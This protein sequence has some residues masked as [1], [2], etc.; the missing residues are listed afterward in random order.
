MRFALVARE[1]APFVGG[2]IAPLVTNAATLLSEVGDVTLI[3]S[4]NHRSAYHAARAAGDP[5]LPPPSVRT[6]FVPEPEDG[7]F[8]NFMSHMHAWSARVHDALRAFYGPRGP[9]LIEFCDYFGEGFVTIQAA[10]TRA[11]W[12]A[13]TSICVRL[14]TSAEMCGVLDGYVGDD[15]ESN[16][17]FDAERYSLLHADRLL[18]CGG[19]V[20][21]TYQRYY[22]ADRLAPGEQVPD[23]FAVQLPP[24]SSRDGGVGEHEPLRLLYLGRLERR[25]GVQD[26]MRAVTALA[27]DDWRLTLVGGDTQTGPLGS[28]MRNML[29][30]MAAG[31]ERIEFVDGVSRGDVGHFIRRAHLLVVPSRWECWPNVVREALMH[32]RPVLATPTGGM[33]EMVQ[34]GRSGWLTEGTDAAALLDAL[35]RIL[36][37]RASINDL[38]EYG[39]PR[40]VFED[41]VD[42]DETVRRY[43]EVAQLGPRRPRRRTTGDP[44]VSIVIPYFCLENYVEETVRSAL[45]QAY[46]NLEVIVVNDGSLRDEDAPLYEL[47]RDL[48]IRVVTQV[49]S[50]LGPARN[51]GILQARG[52]YVLPLDADDLISPEFV[53]RCVEALESDS[54]LAYVTSWVEYMKPDGTPIVDWQG[55]YAPFGNWSRLINRNNVAGTCAAVLRKRLFDIGFRYSADMTSYED[56]LLYRELHAAGHHGAVIPERLF[57]YRVREESMM[58][59]IGVPETPRLVG[60][61]RAHM[62]E[63]ATLWMPQHNGRQ[64]ATS[65]LRR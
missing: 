8:G 41:L 3:T 37:H 10:H 46:T 15:F 16:A 2:G 7:D 26:L 30:L 47:A 65:P 34:P 9:D 59:E 36:D 51:F 40:A 29:E 58:R 31:D 64:H 21:G 62:L 19:D 61:M 57:R 39:R 22:G 25:K 17:V 12:L 11:R 53:A 38:I 60:E 6:L 24:D 20:Y 42:P 23:A 5:R 27:R 28:S 33:R 56:W 63:R 32:N 13:D 1:I 45:G 18:W 48:P 49:N 50:G 14:H 4:A 43:V 35:E 54:D 55:G 52:R 44:L